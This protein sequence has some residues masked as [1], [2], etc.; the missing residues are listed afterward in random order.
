LGIVVSFLLA[1]TEASGAAASEK[2]SQEE[3]A[4]EANRLNGELAELYRQGRYQQALPLAQLIWEVRKQ[5]LGEEHPETLASLNNLAEMYAEVGD[6]ARAEPLHLRAL[7]IR[8]KTLGP[9]HPDTAISLNNLAGLYESIGNY[10]KAEL[11]YKRALAIVNTA[12]GPD[13]LETA[14]ALNNLGELYRDVGAYPKAELFYLRALLIFDKK[15]RPDHTDSATVLNNLA[16]LYKDSGAYS[17]AEPLYRKSLAIRE[18]SL[19]ADHPDTGSSASNLADL[20]QLQGHY[21]IAEP[22]YRRALRITE[23]TFGPDH[24]RTAIA[25]NN[26]ASL[27]KDGGTYET[28][29]PLYQRALAINERALGPDDPHTA[30]SLNNLADL[31]YGMAAYAK[32]EP[33]YQRSLAI[34]E[35]ALGPDHP[36]TAVALNNLA[37]LYYAE[38][39]YEKAEPLMERT[40]AIEEHNTALFVLSGSEARK[41]AY[42]QKREGRVY[43]NVSLSVT[44]P[45]ASSVA[46]GLTSVL[47]YK[48]RVLDAMSDGVSQL[49]RSVIPQDQ[50][51]FDQLSAVTQELSTL[52]FRGAGGLSSEAYRQRLDTLAQDRERLE[53]ALASRSAALRRAVTP[54]TIKNVRQALPPDAVLVEWMR[55]RPFNS[56]VK[57]EARWGGFRYAAYILERTGEPVAIDLGEAQP[58]EDLIAEFR[59]ALGDPMNTYIK[60][61]AHELATKLIQP[62]HLHLAQDQRLLLSPD[63]A[64]NLVPFAALVDDHGEY[65]MQHSELTYLTSG[66]DLL[67][68]AAEPVR[69]S[70]VALANPNFDQKVSMKPTAESVLRPTR[71]G[72][73]DRSGLVFAPLAGTAA[74]AKALQSLLRLDAHDVLTGDRATEANLRRLHGPRI[75]HV[76][77]HGFFLTDQEVSTLFNPVASASETSSPPLGENPL[78]RSGLALAGA[79]LRREGASDDGILTAAETAQLDLLGTQLVVLSACQTGLGA[80]RSGEGVYGLRRALMLAGAQAQLA[81]LWKVADVATL[82]LMVDYY[83]RLLKGEGRSQAL[84]LAQQMM[85]QNPARQHPYYWAAFIS[86]GNWTPLSGQ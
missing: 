8:E 54:I 7:A 77:T 36:A 42:V 55:Y 35:K 78:L 15:G 33:L 41:L 2:V 57:R 59:T 4:Q 22:L 43:T 1:I 28:A 58:I 84:R 17:M 25:L 49:R 38:R 60:D 62:L 83:Q 23:K 68:M 20:Y 5:A 10:A 65:L 86:I 37:L 53:G 21:V 39:A 31:Y 51:L 50:A 46:L 18:Q 79:N 61:L 6:Y 13:S 82:E 26:L 76:A 75:L 9:N 3:L 34:R 24:P 81:S 14:I 66:R 64:L 67:R 11:F 19:G 70:P 73:L 44:D 40:Q 69:G 56:T 27:S 71:S 29:E 80:V 85:L 16:E 48:G 45:T 72:D 30:I 74:E 52:T 12:H 63:G 32:A 47:Q